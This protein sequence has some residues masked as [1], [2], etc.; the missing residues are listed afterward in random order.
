MKKKVNKKIVTIILLGA[1]LAIS[2]PFSFAWYFVNK[3]VSLNSDDNFLIEVGQSLEVSRLLSVD[4]EGKETWSD[5]TSKPI[6]ISSPILKDCSSGGQKFSVPYGYDPD[7][8]AP[9]FPLFNISSKEAA[10]YYVEVTLKFRTNI[11]CGIYLS[12]NSYILPADE[13]KYP[14]PSA[15]ISGVSCNN[16]AGAMRASFTEDIM[17]ST[18]KVVLN[19]LKQVWIPN[20]HYQL[21]FDSKG[22]PS[23]FTKNGYREAKYGYIQ[24]AALEVDR[25][26]YYETS[27]YLNKNVL[28]GDNLAEY[29]SSMTNAS[30]AITS[31]VNDGTV[32]V[33][34]VTVRVWFEGTDREADSAFN[35]GKCQF[36]IAFCAIMKQERSQEDDDRLDDLTGN[37]VAR[38]IYIDDTEEV[39]VTADDNI[40]ISPNGIDWY[41]YPM[42]YI[43]EKEKEQSGVPYYWPRKSRIYAEDSR[44]KWEKV[45]MRNKETPL[46][47]HIK[48]VS[49]D[50]PL[51]I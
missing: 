28:V 43:D 32:Q 37:A 9:L 17:D 20:D 33:K 14:T 40:Q 35:K 38:K 11:T 26:K 18:G 8:N 45:Y 47:E 51:Y 3:D 39:E 13:T 6:T 4:D 27:D 50:M 41:D 44:S 29:K 36:R 42:T 48:A 31:F 10:G 30:K 22:D 34:R 1:L 2:L 19:Q 21:Y 7:T 24:N 46:Q 49:C 23:G 25:Y 12:N 5:Y 16:I 15:W